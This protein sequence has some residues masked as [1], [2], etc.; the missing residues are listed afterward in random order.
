MRRIVGSIAILTLWASVAGAQSTS[1][2]TIAADP[3]TATA[4]DS[5]GAGAQPPPIHPCDVVF[6]PAATLP[7]GKATLEWCAKA[8]DANGNAVVILTQALYVDGTRFSITGAASGAPSPTS[9]LQLYTTGITLVKGQHQYGIASISD[10]GKEGPKSLPF[11]LTVT[12][13]LGPPIAPVIR[14]VR[15]P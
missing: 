11:L 10:E 15:Q 12:A 8:V 1:R 4:L 7:E 6:Q 3:V 14:G 2:D 9:A 5:S 13:V